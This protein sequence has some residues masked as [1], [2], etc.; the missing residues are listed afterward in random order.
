MRRDCRS[1]VRIVALRNFESQLESSPWR[2]QRTEI[3]LREWFAPECTK[4]F[5]TDGPQVV[6]SAHEQR[7][8]GNRR[9]CQ[10]IVAHFVDAQ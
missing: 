3:A 1:E 8:G 9:A 2:P 4:S 10:A 6:L 5:R 7:P